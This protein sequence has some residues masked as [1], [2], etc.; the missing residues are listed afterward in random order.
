[1]AEARVVQD[2]PAIT[3]PAWVNVGM[4]RHLSVA[5]PEPFMEIVRQMTLNEAS[6]AA[7]VRC[8]EDGLELDLN[9]DLTNRLSRF[10]VGKTFVH[11]TLTEKVQGHVS[12]DSVMS[13]VLDTIKKRNVSLFEAAVK[14][15]GPLTQMHRRDS[16]PAHIKMAQ[17]FA[18]T[19]NRSQVSMSA[20]AMIMAKLAHDVST[21]EARSYVNLVHKTLGAVDPLSPAFIRHK[22]KGGDVVFSHFELAFTH[23]NLPLA[24]LMQSAIKAGLLTNQKSKLVDVLDRCIKSDALNGTDQNLASK[25]TWLAACGILPS[26]SVLN[27]PSTI[28]Q[29]SIIWHLTFPFSEKDQFARSQ[30]SISQERWDLGMRTVQPVSMMASAL[31]KHP[32]GLK[33]LIQAGLDVNASNPNNGITPLHVAAIRRD[34]ESVRLLMEHGADP[35]L[36]DA[37]KRTPSDWVGLGMPTDGA[38]PGLEMKPEERS[39]ETSHYKAIVDAARAQ[40]AID[41]TIRASM[42]PM[43]TAPA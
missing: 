17:L 39:K 21:I 29:R 12:S 26:S 42:Q 6:C 1:M 14:Q 28:K 18:S 20:L 5:H 41:Q 2:S 15:L 11:R 33:H 35:D 34:W 40:R 24:P 31:Q 7:L 19:A 10:P 36:K 22:A 43:P 13:C 37:R 25:V 32:A 3:D 30:D 9:Q 23:S 16:L 38:V 8:M 27:A 4:M